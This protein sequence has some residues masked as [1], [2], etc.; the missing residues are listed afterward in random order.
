VVIRWKSFKRGF[1]F[2]PLLIVFNVVIA[3]LLLVIGFHFKLIGVFVP[4]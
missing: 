2:L 4:L 1:K 3:Q